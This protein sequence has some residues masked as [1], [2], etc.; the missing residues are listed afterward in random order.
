MG[1]GDIANCENENDE[2]T[3]ALL[4]RIS[5]TVF[6]AGD[7]VYEDGT[8]EEFTNCYE[9][10]WGRHKARTR[11]AIGNHEY[12]SGGG[13]YYRYFGALAG[14]PS[15]GYYSYDLGAWHIVV[16]NTNCRFVGG[17]EQ[18]SPQERWL[19][20]DLAGHSAY[21]TLAYAHHPRFS[22]GR[23]GDNQWMQA[24]WQALHAGGVD[25]FLAGHEH[26]YERFAPLDGQGSAAPAGGVR[27]FIV[28]T[29]GKSHYPFETSH[30]ESLVR[31]SDTYGVLK[32]SLHPNSY[33]WEFIPV[34][35]AS[36]RDSGTGECH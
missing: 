3:A 29:G 7:S 32:L 26:N 1:A 17:C 11:P 24:L 6:V 21:C 15:K 14:E 8:V 18:G 36:F 2:A 25:V 33:D 22:S 5:G 9:P 12:R 19:R 30:P 31:N 34:E 35:G 13:G 20:E 16:L 4:D 23:H 28:G 10:T 27:Q